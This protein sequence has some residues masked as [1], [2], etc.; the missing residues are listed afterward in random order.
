MDYALAIKAMVEHIAR[1]KRMRDM[2]L[3]IKIAGLPIETAPPKCVH[4][5]EY[6]LA[7]AYHMAQVRDRVHAPMALAP[8][9]GEIILR[10]TVVTDCLEM[11][12]DN[13]L[14]MSG[15]CYVRMG[16]PMQMQI[17]SGVMPASIFV[18]GWL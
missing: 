5:D 12:H 13:P 2:A 1:D 15:Y 8:A 4:I 6:R 7:E 3:E 11:S 16:L 18:R 9:S 17:P 10:G 14:I